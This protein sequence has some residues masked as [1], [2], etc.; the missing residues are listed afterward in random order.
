MHQGNLNFF[1]SERIEFIPNYGTIIMHILLL[2]FL[3]ITMTDH[4][5]PFLQTD[6]KILVL[7]LRWNCTTNFFLFLLH[8]FLEIMFCLYILFMLFEPL[9]F[10]KKL[11]IDN[12]MSIDNQSVISIHIVFY[13][14][15]SNW[16]CWSWLETGCNIHSYVFTSSVYNCS[17]WLFSKTNLN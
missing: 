2:P 9:S 1:T 12:Y 15:L 13:W 16:F 3:S 14:E 7:I 17:Q 11:L 4:G 10:G 8:S 5:K 6:I